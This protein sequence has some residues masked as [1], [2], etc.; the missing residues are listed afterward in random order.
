MKIKLMPTIDFGDLPKI[1]QFTIG[2]VGIDLYCAIDAII[3]PKQ[4]YDITC[5]LKIELPPG[6]YARITGRSST[7]MLGL[8]I[9]EGIIDQDFRGE[10]FVGAYNFSDETVY[11]K[12][13]DRLAQMIICKYDAVEVEYVDKLTETVR[14]EGGFGSTDTTVQYVATDFMDKDFFDEYYVKQGLSSMEISKRFNVGKTIVLQRMKEC[15]VNVLKS[16]ERHPPSLSMPQQMLIDGGLLG[17]MSVKHNKAWTHARCDFGHGPNQIDYLRY[18]RDI[19]GKFVTM[20][21]NNQYSKHSDSVTFYFC[22]VTHP[23]FTDFRNKYYNGSNKFVTSELLNRLKPFSLAIWYM[24]DGSLHVDKRSISKSISLH[25]EGFN[26]ESQNLILSWLNDNN[27]E[28]SIYH[29]NKDYRFI[30]LNASGTRR[31]MYVVEPHIIPSM[32]YKVR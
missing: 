2:S 30:S 1:K 23:I 22:T 20:D 13:G 15:N 17:D 27:Y 5:G 31:F 7:F 28:A 12:R 19:M 29:T 8:D 4:K 25:V 6:Y 3:M 24:D 21:I 18:K 26:E 16:W 9:R 11:I 32:R 14:N 10:L